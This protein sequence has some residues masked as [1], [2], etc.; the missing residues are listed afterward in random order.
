MPYV[1]AGS[2]QGQIQTGRY[3]DYL[4]DVTPGFGATGSQ[5]HNKLFV[6]FMNLLGIDENSF[7]LTDA[8]FSG[9]LPGLV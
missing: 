6:S 8:M 4:G 9:P 2:C 3:I 1:L 7:G 5:P